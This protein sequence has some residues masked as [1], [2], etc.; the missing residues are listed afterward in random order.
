MPIHVSLVVLAFAYEIPVHSMEQQVLLLLVGG[1]LLVYHVRRY[2]ARRELRNIR[3]PPSPSW[4]MGK[5]SE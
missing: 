1:A 5:L 2:L 4:L 3:G